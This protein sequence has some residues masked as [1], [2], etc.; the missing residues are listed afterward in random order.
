MFL[1]SQFQ[2]KLGLFDE[3]KINSNKALE[4]LEENKEEFKDDYGILAVKYYL[5]A[6]NICFIMSDFEQAK[7]FAQKGLEIIGVTKVT[8][9][10]KQPMANSNRD[11]L[12]VK[13]RSSNKLDSTMD[14]W[15]L[16]IEE[17]QSNNMDL[18]LMPKEEE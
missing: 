10:T 5:Q 4:L 9:E 1:T 14:P 18:T 13:I 17:A 6:A 3:S 12:N 11:L 2:L 8:P 7:N 16:R 15:K